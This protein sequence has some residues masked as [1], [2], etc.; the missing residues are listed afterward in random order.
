MMIAII[1]GS[2]LL[3]GGGH[4]LKKISLFIYKT[5]RT[6]TPPTC[7]KNSIWCKKTPETRYKSSFSVLSML[8]STLTYNKVS[9]SKWVLWPGLRVPLGGD[10]IFYL[11][12]SNFFVMELTFSSAQTRFYNIPFHIF[13]RRKF[14]KTF[15]VW[16]ISKLSIF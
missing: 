7:Q 15:L 8:S 6:Q 10:N 16:F 2:G 1:F 14:L 5:H 12:E 13:S 11:V 9:P 4:L 3:G